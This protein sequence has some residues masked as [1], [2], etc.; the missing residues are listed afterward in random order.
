MTILTDVLTWT[1]EV[2]TPLGPMGVFIVAFMESSFFPIP[3]DILII[4][5]ALAAPELALFYALIATIGSVTG[6]FFGYYI[7]LKGGRPALLK[8]AGKK[9]TQQV[10]DYF[11][12]YG[13]WAI[14]IAGFTPIPYKIFTIAA[15]AFRHDLKKLFI[16]SVI[17]R[18]ARF[19]A[20]AIVI[21]LWGDAII[22]F[23]DQY[24]AIF[25]IGITAIIVIGY[26]G[27]KKYFK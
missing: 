24:F 17:S 3:P 12:R 27:Y 9:R 10:E 16:A 23:I 11:S 13:T 19:F 6:A 22:T 5:L 1:N 15:G 8:L 25:T 18:S 7:G 4:P 21:L 26:F 2:F 14:G 20:I